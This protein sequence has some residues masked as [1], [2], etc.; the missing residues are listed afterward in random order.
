MA[1]LLLLPVYVIAISILAHLQIPT[2]FESSWLLLIF[3]TVFIGLIP[4]AIAYFAAR[5]YIISG[6]G[7]FMLMGC[8]ML[9]FG[10]SSISAALLISL[11]DGPNILVTIHNSGVLFGSIL[12]TI[13]GMLFIAGGTSW[14]VRRKGAWRIIVIYSGI[15][16]LILIF[17]LATALGYLPRFFIQGTGPTLLRQLVLI[18]AMNL[19][20]I[21]A[22]LF[23]I[24]YKKMR[25]DFLYWYGLSLAMIS[26]GL[27]G[28]V[29]Q[30]SVGCPIGWLGRSAQYVGGLFG[31]IAILKAA[32]GAISHKISAEE[33]IALLFWDVESSYKNLVESVN[34]SII[35]FDQTERIIG[36]NPSAQRMFDRSKNETIGSNFFDL[37]VPDKYSDILRMQIESL[38]KSSS[39]IIAANVM[40]MEARRKEGSIFPVE[41]SLSLRE[42][43]L[44]W[45][46]TCIV[47]DVS[48]RK[49]AQDKLRESEEKF[50]TVANFTYDW[51]FWVGTDGR[52]LYVSPSCERVTGY[53]CNEFLS[54]PKLISEIVHPED[55]SIVGDYLKIIDQRPYYAAE[56]R[57][58]TRKGEERWIEHHCQ[59]VYDHEG[60]FR[61]RRGSRR[62]VT[63]R[64]LAEKALR[65]SEHRFRQL[66]DGHH[67]VML[68]IEPD[69]GAIIDGNA[70]AIKYYGYPHNDLC[71]MSIQDINCLP[72]DEILMERQRAKREERNYFVFPHR[73][74]SGEV[75]T[76]EVHSSP[77]EVQGQALLF[78]I[79]HDI[80]ESKR[81]EQ[82]RD[83][84]FNLSLDMLCIAG[85]DGFFKQVNPAWSNNL[86]WSSEELTAKP[87]I[88]FVHPTDRTDCLLAVNQLERESHLMSWENRY[89]HKDGGYRWLSW[90]TTILRDEPLSFSVIRDVTERKRIEQEKQK[91]INDLQNALS[92]VKK[93]SGLIPICSSCKK[94]RDDKGY[95]SEV[96]R[97]IGEHSEAQFSH[98]ICPDCIRKLYPEYADE[99]LGFSEKDEKK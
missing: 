66:F 73:L 50:R 24:H 58:V 49:L 18:S 27:L 67:A 63:N 93:L 85:H 70:A 19:Y 40:E 34:D 11:P 29:L 60:S 1:G 84:L 64:K 13:G 95:W 30:K 90:N 82:E 78:S 43:P 10:L 15:V 3:N 7:S 28:I 4:I 99:V 14:T 92:E 54:D 36:W 45:L 35:T 41:L 48:E 25:S 74:A 65:D 17:S 97:Y 69:S 80:T 68:L 51:E 20:V 26:I 46:C 87:W 88:E 33:S 37:I 61:G 22:A 75:R 86:G 57:I 38:V 52:F 21:S 9:T 23:M 81:T 42:T 96:E 44:G 5:V 89:L 31:L 59:P 71:Q 94:I 91:L 6:T 79:V 8:G 32:S 62:D 47:R 53:G 83:R 39:K 77:I 55:R 2:I 76:V 12:Q 56:F 16:V 98:G 72:P